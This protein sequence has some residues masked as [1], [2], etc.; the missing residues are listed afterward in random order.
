MKTF[1]ALAIVPAL[2]LLL[3]AGA[4]AR[5]YG[6]SGRMTQPMQPG[7]GMMQQQQ[8]FPGPDMK[9]GSGQLGQ[10]EG[11]WYYG[12]LTSLNPAANEIVINTTVP[13]LLG[14]QRADVPFSTSPDTTLSICFRSLNACDTY[15]AGENGWDVLSSL[16]SMSSLSG[17]NN[18]ALVIGNPDTNQ[19]VHVQI[20]YGV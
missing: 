11:V 12:T 17:A 5:D 15:F 1:K 8:Q 10:G 2:V 14:A 6:K 7:T 18:R 16:Q 9:F 20:E 3:A 4:V 19:V 13:G